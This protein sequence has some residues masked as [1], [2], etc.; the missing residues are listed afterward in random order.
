MLTV[1]PSSFPGEVAHEPFGDDLCAAG[2]RVFD[3]RRGPADDLA[4]PG[5]RWVGSIKKAD[6][7]GK[8][9]KRRIKLT[10]SEYVLIIKTREGKEF[11]GEVLRHKGQKITEVAGTIT[12]KGIADFRV[13][14]RLKGATADDIVDNGRH[15][16]SFKGEEFNGYFIIPGN[17]ARAGE[18]NLKLEKSVK[19]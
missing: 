11:T 19:P 3:G 10:S 2:Q 4:Q 5:T 9:K 6:P 16:G 18:V 13:A 1:V 8:G 17:D 7:E 12:D 15:H 14:K